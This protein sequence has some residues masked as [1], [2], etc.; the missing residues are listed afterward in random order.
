MANKKSVVGRNI[1][2]ALICVGAASVGA[3]A[4]ISFS[5]NNAV[6][7]ESQF[8]I[9]LNGGGGFNGGGQNS[10]ATNSYG[11]V[12]GDALAMDETKYY[13]PGDGSA[14]GKTAH[15][16]QSKTTLSTRGFRPDSLSDCN[17][18]G[19]V[20]APYNVDNDDNGGRNIDHG[21]YWAFTFYVENKLEQGSIRL[22]HKMNIVRDATITLP[23]IDKEFSL[24]DVLRVRTFVN[25][26]QVDVPAGL[27]NYGSNATTYARGTQTLAQEFAN[28]DG[29]DERGNV[30]MSASGGRELISDGENSKEDNKCVYNYGFATAFHN[31]A[32]FSGVACEVAPQTVVRYTL[33]MW[34][35][36]S[37][38]EVNIDGYMFAQSYVKSAGLSLQ[39][40]L[41]AD[42]AD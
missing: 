34:L 18:A 25:E 4:I 36:G 35:E 23:R 1:A 22:N 14:G 16:T 27:E 15:V 39:L 24:L 32:I 6:T 19:D 29:R 12:I 7:N 8:T 21:T 3:F 28:P 41:S 33:L 40:E 5:R 20:P 42:F 9:V 2:I 30:D 37:D 10:S 11:E 38:P 17:A 13:E 31:D 26:V